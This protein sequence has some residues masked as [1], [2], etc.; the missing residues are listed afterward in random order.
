MTQNNPNTDQGPERREEMHVQGID[1]LARVRELIH[2]GNVRRI[3]IRHEGHT[4]M[5]LPLTIGVVS[6]FLA[7][8]LAAV[9]AI[10]ALVANCSIEVVRSERP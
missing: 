6:A 5:E 2:E 3:I 8:S 7:P 9:G 1:L 4:I 10:G